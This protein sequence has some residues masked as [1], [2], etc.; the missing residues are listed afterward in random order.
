VSHEFNY[1]DIILLNPRHASIFR[2]LISCLQLSF[3]ETS[4]LDSTNVEQVL[5]GANDAVL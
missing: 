1:G 4:A 3:I 2:L 5:H